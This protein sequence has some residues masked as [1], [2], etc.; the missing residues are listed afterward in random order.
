MIRHS[1]FI[2]TAAAILLASDL[3][4]ATELTVSTHTAAPAGFSVNSHL[5]QGERDAILVDAQ[6]TLSEAAQVVQL[7]QSSGK[8]LKYIIVTHGHPDHFFGLEV[9][10]HAFPD[11]RIVATDAVIADIQ[12]Y[13]P[14]AIA[15]WKPVFKEQ[16]RDSFLTPKPINSTSLFLEGNEIQLLT[17]DG[18]ESAHA[19]V[20]WIPSTQALLT[21]DLTYN[22]VHLWLRENRPQGWLAILDRFEQ[23]QPLAVYP[24]HGAPGGPNVIAADRE[25]IETFVAATAVPATKEQAIAALKSKYSDY[26]LPVVVEFSVGGRLEK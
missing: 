23:L 10:Q 16:I 22:K 7:V 21:G 6:F 4:L 20:L 25:Y 19:T 5:I 8:Q 3:T 15:R 13:G 1:I 12:D 17:M 14:K 26:A 11:A 18:G 24:G 2:L 9:L